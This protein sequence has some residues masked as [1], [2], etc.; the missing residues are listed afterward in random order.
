MQSNNPATVDHTENT[1]PVDPD[2]ES[3]LPK[4]QSPLRA[5]LASWTTFQRE[6]FSVIG[7]VLVGYSVKTE[8]GANASLGFL[9]TSLLSYWNITDVVDAAVTAPDYFKNAK[10]SMTNH[11]P[12]TIIA[13]TNVIYFPIILLIIT[14][15]AIAETIRSANNAG[16]K[17]VFFESKKTLGSDTAF[18]ASDFA[19]GFGL[20][21]MAAFQVY[22]WMRARHKLSSE[23]ILLED[24]L[25]K[26][27]CFSSSDDVSDKKMRLTLQASAL[28]AVCADQHNDFFSTLADV[29]RMQISS[30]RTWN[31]NTALL[32]VNFLN[33]KQKY[34]LSKNRADVLGNF[35]GFIGATLS[36]LSMQ[37]QGREKQWLLSSVIFYSMHAVIKIIQLFSPIIFEKKNDIEDPEH[38][39]RQKLKLLSEEKTLDFISKNDLAL[40]KRFPSF[41]DEV[42]TMQ[43]ASTVSR[44]PNTLPLEI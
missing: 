20:L 29:E 4:E 39:I 41:W 7:T 22:P 37:D 11:F 19:F 8:G 31:A 34:K 23:K 25:E 13:W 6:F 3:F 16:F 24:R 14:T 9:I 36:A 33:N 17:N 2:R 27:K 21:L 28:M 30:A 44:A 10:K 15:W 18:I 42:S 35:L 12:K 43:V 40:T 38:F 1:T 32:L 26:I 5:K